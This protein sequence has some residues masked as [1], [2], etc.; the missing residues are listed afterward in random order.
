MALARFPVVR[1]LVLVSRSLLVQRWWLLVARRP[2]LVVPVRQW[3]A[4]QV[5][6]VVAV[7]LP[8]LVVAGQPQPGQPVVV[9][10]LAVLLVEVLLAVMPLVAALPGVDQLG[11]VVLLL[12]KPSAVP[13]LDLQPRVLP[14]VRL[15]PVLV[16]VVVLLPVV[17]AVPLP[18][19]ALAVLL[20]LVAVLILLPVDR[21]AELLLLHQAVRVP[22]RPVHPALFLQGHP[23]TALLQAALP[24]RSPR[25]KS[26]KQCRK[27]AMLKA[28]PTALIPASS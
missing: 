2:L 13:M 18:A 7:V 26:V 16:L 3:V 6:W 28:S 12:Q 20:L 8:L 21:L 14:L 27:W 15:A 5:P 17:Q 4:A 24:V 25:T 23:R 22:I 10:R 9:R 19:R 1:L 11:V